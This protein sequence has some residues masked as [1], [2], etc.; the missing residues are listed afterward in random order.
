EQG[1]WNEAASRARSL[2]EP[3][4][5]DSTAVRWLVPDG[6]VKPLEEVVR[7]GNLMQSYDQLDIVLKK[8]D[9]ERPAALAA[10]RK[11][12]FDVLSRPLVH[13][14]R[15]LRALL[16]LPALSTRQEP[17]LSVTNVRQY[18]E[19]LQYCS[20]DKVLM[21]HVQQDLAVQ[22]FLAGHPAQAQFLLPED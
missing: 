20:L 12:D 10:L 11:I 19:D 18:I 4:K 7:L 14:A 8:L 13:D 16:E 15:G 6:L 21:A 2:Q 22:R 17:A 3:S 9:N 1:H 5:K